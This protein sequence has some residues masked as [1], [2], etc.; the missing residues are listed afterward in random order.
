MGKLDRSLI[1]R[2][3]CSLRR[4]IAAVYTPGSAPLLSVVLDMS[5]SINLP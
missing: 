3:R 4:G 5:V 2:S 1:R